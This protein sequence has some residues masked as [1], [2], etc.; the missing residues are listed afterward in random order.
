MNKNLL[1]KGCQHKKKRTNLE[2]S[3]L[4]PQ[5]STKVG[6]Y[7]HLCEGRALLPEFAIIY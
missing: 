7:K 4:Y 1:M 2:R 6:W 3:V 5:V